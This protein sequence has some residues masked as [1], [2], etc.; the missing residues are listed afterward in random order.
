MAHFRDLELVKVFLWVTILGKWQFISGSAIFVSI[1]LWLWKKKEYVIYLWLMLGIGLVFDYLGKIL[2]RRVRP[3]DPA[4]LETSFSFPSGHASMSMIFYGFAAYVLVRHLKAWRYRVNAFFF[5]SIV[6]VAIGFS[7]LYLGVH[8]WSDVWA[9]YLLGFLILLAATSVYEWSVWGEKVIKTASFT[10][11]MKMFVVS[12]VLANVIFYVTIG[13]NYNPVLLKSGQ[14]SIKN[15]N[16]DIISYFNDHKIGKRTETLFGNL[17]E[18]LSFIF[19]AKSDD[20]LVKSFTAATWHQAEK[21]SLNSVSRV[22]KAAMSSG[23]YLNAPVTPYF[24]NNTVNDFGFQK[25]TE[26]NNIKERHHLRVWKTDLKQGDYLVYVGTASLDIG[27]K[28]FITHRISPDI[29]TEK[30]Y[31][32]DSL[33]NAGVV[34]SLKKFNF[35]IRFGAKISAEIC[36]LQT[37]NFLLLSLIKYLQFI[38]KNP[39]II[40]D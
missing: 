4:Y 30:I 21:V 28:W 35:L 16:G 13:F 27:I 24:W 40:S 12:L 9:G 39:L 32:K 5:C 14:G 18:P 15:V 11:K 20:D 2:V 23:Q 17:Q 37:E 8:Y 22:A 10:K 29:D 38:Y 6:I 33:Q 19:L 7:R 25:P 34:D 31:I 3:I 1:V 36:S 26:I